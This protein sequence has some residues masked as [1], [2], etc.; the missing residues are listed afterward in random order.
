MRVA[1]V[2]T[3][4]PAAPGDPSGH[5]V[6]TEAAELER[7]G[8]EVFVVAPPSGGAFGWPGVAARLRDNPLRAP[9]AVRWVLAARR[10]V[11][12]LAPARIVAHWAAPSAW[13]IG[14]AA[15]DARLDVVSHGGDVRLIAGLPRP[16]RD[17]LA[18]AVADRAHEWRFVSTSLRDELLRSLGAEARARVDRIAVVRAASMEMAELSEVRRRAV[19]LRRELGAPNLTVCVGRLVEIKRVDRAIEHVARSGSAGVLVVVGD[20][21]E[22]PRL[23]RLARS[24]GVDARFVG[25]VTREV[26]LAWIAAADVVLH[27]SSAEGLS[28]VVREADAL[29]TRVIRL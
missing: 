1:V 23:E 27:A 25:A 13:P 15:R 26:A 14:V 7:A 11:R 9:E 18:R 3:S 8:D 17:L 4:W 28:T 16:L 21:P 24:L 6:R 5:F 10:R 12:A 20:G 2:T 29:G 22:R 19:A